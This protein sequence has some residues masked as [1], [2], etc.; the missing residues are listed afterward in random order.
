VSSAK[1]CGRAVVPSIGEPITFSEFIG[2]P[3]A[4][5]LVM[6]AEPGLDGVISTRELAAE[7]AP[8]SAALLV[9]PEGGWAEAEHRL[10]LE[11]NATL[12]TLGHRTL[13]A[14]AAPLVALSVLQHLWGDL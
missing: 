7:P 3:V 11:C 14:D 6:L 4:E 8:A 12:V 13:R 5:R 10:A 2:K 9:G 1:Q